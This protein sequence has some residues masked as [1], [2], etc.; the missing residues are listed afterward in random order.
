MQMQIQVGY[1]RGRGPRS[2]NLT[3]SRKKMGKAIA[4]GSRLSI[5]T[6]CL[7]DEDISKHVI[8]KVGRMVHSEIVALCSDRV[9]STLKHHSR[10]ELLN[11]KWGDIYDELQ[12]HAPI[13]LEILL[14][15]TAT[16]CARP[17]R[18]ALISMCAAMICKLRSPHMNAAQKILSLILYAGHASK[19]VCYIAYTCTSSPCHYTMT[20]YGTGFCEATQVG[21]GYVA[22]FNHCTGG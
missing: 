17:N 20:P 11:F 19:Q 9:D 8:K 5:A 12:Q 6:Q 16:N 10:D 13:L 14:A 21:F 2:Y 4:R 3:P 15:A 1:S 22:F 18:E 7:N